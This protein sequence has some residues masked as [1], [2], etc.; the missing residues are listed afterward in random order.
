MLALNEGYPVKEE[1]NV[2]SVTQRAEQRL[3]KEGRWEVTPIN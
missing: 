1:M 3:R 2:F